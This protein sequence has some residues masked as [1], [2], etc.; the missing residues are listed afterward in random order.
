MSFNDLAARFKQAQKHDASEEKPHN[1]QESFRLRGKVLGVLIRD[2][3]L[4]SARTIEDCARLLNTAPAMIESWEY[5]E[6]VPSLPQLELLAYY[7][8]VP[9]S[10]FWSQ[11]ALENDRAKTA[12]KQPAYLALRD[13]M[14]GAQ[15]HQARMD[16]GLSLEAVSES[17]QLDAELIDQYEQGEVSIPMTHL[18][19]LANAVNKNVNY[20]LESVGYV[21]ELLQAREDWQAFMALDEDTRAFVANPRNLAFIKIA[22]MFRDMPTEQ[23]RKVAEGLLDITM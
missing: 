17:S 2:A 20:F 18:Q 6:E 4:D 23:L 12:T 8:D 22:M 9:V 10:H 11:N 3:R 14:I 13:R 5:G 16:Y 15:L 19:I 7:L 1:T 21:G